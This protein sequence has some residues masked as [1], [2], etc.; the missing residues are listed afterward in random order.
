MKLILAIAAM[1][2]LGACDGQSRS[3]T[4]MM[5]TASD[6]PSAV[7]IDEADLTPDGAE[8]MRAMIGSG[9]LYDAERRKYVV[10][11]HEHTDWGVVSLKV[12]ATPFT[13]VADGVQYT[14]VV[15]VANPQ[16]TL[17]V[18]QALLKR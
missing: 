7:V 2:V 13:V 4:G 8:K 17:A 11:V 12:L 5:W 3:I 15:A 16:I 6:S 1:L 9:V 14:V 18:V 10:A